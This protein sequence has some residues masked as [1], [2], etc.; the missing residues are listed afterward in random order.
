MAYSRSVPFNDLPNL[1]PL[2]FVESPEI[3]KHLV[4]AIP[5]FRRAKWK[6]FKN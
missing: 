5:L 2:D 3:L 4:R 6:L 1:P